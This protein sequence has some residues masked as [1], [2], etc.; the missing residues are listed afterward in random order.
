[1]NCKEVHIPVKGKEPR[2]PR[3]YLRGWSRPFPDMGCWVGVVSVLSLV[4]EH[5][6]A[7]A[8]DDG[9]KS[10]VGVG[11]VVLKHAAH[12]IPDDAKHHDDDA[13]DLA[14]LTGRS[15]LRHGDSLYPVEE[16]S[17]CGIATG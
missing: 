6:D 2:P 13:G 10:L 8:N 9:G 12:D 14:D 5:E 16:R 15:W 4:A 1:M 17:T 7:D 3:V 11:L